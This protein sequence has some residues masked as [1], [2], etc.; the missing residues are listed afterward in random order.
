[1]TIT[2]GDAIVIPFSAGSFSIT[3]P[4]AIVCRPPLAELARDA[5]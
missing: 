1:M 4:N 2:K 3:G 5:E